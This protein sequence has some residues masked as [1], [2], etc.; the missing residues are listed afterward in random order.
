M[1][2]EKKV[3]AAPKMPISDTRAVFFGDDH[4]LRI[5]EQPRGKPEY[6]ATR[7]D[8]LTNFQLASRYGSLGLLAHN[9]EAGKYFQEL[10]IGD[11]LRLMDGSGNSIPYCVKYIKRYQALSPRSPRSKF[12]DLETMEKLGAADVFKRVYMGDGTKVVLQTCIAEGKEEE[13]G[14]LFVICEPQK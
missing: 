7:K 5:V 8:T 13:W 4:Y 10:K 14:R 6:V 2:N 1:D 12:V 3:S 9:F 11:A